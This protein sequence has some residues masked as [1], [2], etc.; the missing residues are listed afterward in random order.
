M[1]DP[2]RRALKRILTYK[3]VTYS[4]LLQYI[5]QNYLYFTGSRWGCDKAKVCGKGFGP[6]E[7]FYGCS[8][9]AVD[10]VKA[11]IYNDPLPRND[12]SGN[13]L[14]LNDLGLSQ[15]DW[16]KRKNK[17]NGHHGFQMP[18]GIPNAA[19]NAST[20]T[21]KVHKYL[22]KSMSRKNSA[23]KDAK[24]LRAQRARDVDIQKLAG[25]KENYVVYTPQR[26]RVQTKKSASAKR[27]VEQPVVNVNEP[28]E[29]GVVMDAARKFLEDIT[30]NA[31]IKYYSQGGSSQ[32]D[33]SCKATLRYDKNPIVQ[34]YCGSA[35]VQDKFKCP[36]LLC[37]CRA[38]LNDIGRRQGEGFRNQISNNNVIDSNNQIINI[39]YLKKFVS[40]LID[41]NRLLESTTVSGDLSNIP[42]HYIKKAATVER[43]TLPPVRVAGVTKP[44]LGRVK[45]YG[46][47]NQNRNHGTQMD[48]AVTD[49]S[50]TQDR[51]QFNK[52]MERHLAKN[53]SKSKEPRKNSQ[54]NRDVPYG[55]V[56][57]TPPQISLFDIQ[58]ENNGDKFNSFIKS[59]IRKTD[60][61]NTKLA[62]NPP[63]SSLN[64]SDV[65]PQVMKCTAAA[66][67]ANNPFMKNW[68][69][70]NC[71]FG[72]CPTNVCLCS[73]ANNSSLK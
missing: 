52:V 46:R 71:P 44:I 62:S 13:T 58:T 45:V 32:K 22:L 50:L 70:A 19:E 67:F 2:L 31:I 33:V 7:E 24:S 47:S 39:G 37:T 66:E 35:C 72:F 51:K 16:G 54:R 68:C 40:N 17:Q 41:R 56:A 21:H 53:R 55:E 28:S 25:L 4:R 43:T 1:T 8:D 12:S 49:N 57:S 42:D 20:K 3:L 15:T 61:A 26:K 27:T 6:Q 36:A 48:Y 14:G 5:V 60:I 69:M 29:S 63:N 30:F 38:S 65:S 73:K 59:T 23:R 64:K 11:V 34:H 10:N 18:E 9:I